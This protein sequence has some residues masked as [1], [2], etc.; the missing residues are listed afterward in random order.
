MPK[1][2]IHRKPNF[3]YSVRKINVQIND[4]E[5]G[6]IANGETVSFDCKQG[7]NS[8]M[9][10]IKGA[11]SNVLNFEVLDKD[12]QVTAQISKFD[13]WATVMAFPLIPVL[14]ISTTPKNFL[15]IML[16]VIV[17]STAYYLSQYLLKLNSFVLS[18]D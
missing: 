16:I 7:K 12:I 15:T 6:M 13:T 8:I 10:H 14:V 18:V 9:L 1:I 3:L 5:I 11:K 2:I 17:F 4:Q